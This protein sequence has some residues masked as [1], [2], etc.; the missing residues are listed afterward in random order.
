MGSVT[1]FGHKYQTD[2]FVRTEVNIIALQVAYAG[3]IILFSITALIILYHDIVTG[4]SMAI[5]TALTSTTAL[6]S[7]ASLLVAL[8]AVRTQEIVGLVVSIITAAAIFGYLVGR[9]ALAPTRNA[10]AAQKQFIGNIAH[11]VR[12]PLS[13]IKTNTEVAL[14]DTDHMAPSIRKTL[15]SNIEE[16]DRIS[17]IINNL[18]SLN[19]LI[20]PE[21]IPFENVDVAKVINR[22]VSKLNRLIEQ[23]SIRIKMRVARKRVVWGNIAGIEQILMNILK[24]AVHHTSAGDILI[25]IGSNDHEAIEV[26][27]RD[28]GSG[29]KREDLYRIF[30]PFYRG[31][32]ARTRNGGAGSGLGL[33]IVSELVK[34]H[35]GRISIQSAPGQGTSVILTLP[36]GKVSQNQSEET[37]SEMNEISADFSHEKESR[38]SKAT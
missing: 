8:K 13:I 30:E 28:S 38:K 4:I 9:L 35:H 2:F 11:E 36:A 6:P 32:Q 37:P 7:G 15:E 22:V 12:T 25:S 27:V 20:R 26:S 3:V 18:L 16:L 5:A 33:T 14:L 29:I 1:D 17:S 23:K 10:L 31:D 24:N 21:Q 19:A 34:L